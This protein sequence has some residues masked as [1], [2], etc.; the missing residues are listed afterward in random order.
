MSVSVRLPDGQFPR[1]RVQQGAAAP[2]CGAAIEN[3]AAV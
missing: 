2:R 1:V 3:P